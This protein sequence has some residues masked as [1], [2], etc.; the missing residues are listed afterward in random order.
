MSVH[1]SVNDPICTSMFEMIST[2][3]EIQVTSPSQKK[4]KRPIL[5][6]LPSLP[7]WLPP[8]MT[9]A[10]GREMQRLS[11]L[12]PFLSVSCLNEDDPLFATSV[13]PSGLS[14]FKDI[15]LFKKIQQTISSIRSVS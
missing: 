4:P 8:P 2:L 11:F 13:V 5:D 14:D 3:A 9:V 12:G 6:F 7:N 1:Y 15:V 10:E